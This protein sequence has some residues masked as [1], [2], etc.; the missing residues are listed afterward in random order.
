[1]TFE[2]AHEEAEIR[3]GYSVN[4]RGNGK[5]VTNPLLWQSSKSEHR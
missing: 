1:M 4:Y 2:E 3:Q 5:N